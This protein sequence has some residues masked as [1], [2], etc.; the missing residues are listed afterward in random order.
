VNVDIFKVTI[1]RLDHL[2]LPKDSRVLAI[3]EQDISAGD[4][5][6]LIRRMKPRVPPRRIIDATVRDDRPN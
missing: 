2:P 6:A 3:A 1:A 5:I 4:L